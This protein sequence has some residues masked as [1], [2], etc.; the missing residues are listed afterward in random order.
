MA[1]CP[2]RA[3][4]AR[5]RRRV[6]G[7]PQVSLPSRLGGREGKSAKRREKRRPAWSPPY[8]VPSGCERPRL[9]AVLAALRRRTQSRG[10]GGE[11]RA[12]GRQSWS[13][14]EQKRLK[15]PTK[16]MSGYHVRSEVRMWETQAGTDH[17]SV[18][19]VAVTSPRAV[20]STMKA[21]FKNKKVT[22]T[23]ERDFETKCIFLTLQ[24]LIGANIS[25]G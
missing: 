2:R 1:G 3:R 18:P 8:R 22:T 17:P 24:V 10:E 20:L 13:P 23:C 14:A 4:E 5:Y 15:L 12:I 25:C 21:D 9:R 19:S 11:H 7:L 6:P 16:R